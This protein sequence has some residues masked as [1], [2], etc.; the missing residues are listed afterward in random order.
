M[1]GFILRQGNLF[2]ENAGSLYPTTSAAMMA[3]AALSDKSPEDQLED[4][5]G[6]ASQITMAIESEMAN[7]LSYAVTTYDKDTG[8]NTLRKKRSIESPLDSTQLV[9]RLLKHI[10]SNNDYQNIA[11]EK[12]MSAQE[13]ADKYN[14][15][16]KAD[17]E[18]LS[19]L[20]LAGNEQVKELTS[21]IKDACDLK[22]T[23]RCE[24]QV[25]K[26]CQESNKTNIAVPA[27][28]EKFQTHDKDFARYNSYFSES[29]PISC[30][31]VTP[32][33]SFYDSI[34]YNPNEYSYCPM[35]QVPSNFMFDEPEELVGEEIEETVSSKVFIE[36][37]QEPGTSTV[38]HVTHYT[39]TEKS[40]FRKPHI[41]KLPEQMQYYFFLM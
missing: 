13:I 14:I 29:Q 12:M 24:S 11:I 16:F 28:K 31:P 19:D 32:R 35:E 17:P 18:I 34:S 30:S 5:K 23:S 9:M 4:I 38:N 1:L 40:H 33:P 41:E 26:N 36:D 7:L 27:T 10:K 21:I 3:Q 2:A 25:I 15:P 8:K 37:E 22:N 6:I 20:A 39:I